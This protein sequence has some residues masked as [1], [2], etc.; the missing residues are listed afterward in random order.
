[1]PGLGPSVQ[2]NSNPGD[3]FSPRPAFLMGT[4]PP[5]GQALVGTEKTR[6]GAAGPRPAG[7]CANAAGADIATTAESN[8]FISMVSLKRI[9]VL[10][11]PVTN[12]I[13]IVLCGRPA[14]R[15]SGHRTM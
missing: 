13:L 9:Q 1:M 3:L 6:R 2:W 12:A 8:A 10:Q 14:H 4:S 11:W 7:A 15:R 5:S